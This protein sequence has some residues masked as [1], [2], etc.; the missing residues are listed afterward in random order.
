MTESPSPASVWNNR[1]SYLMTLPTDLKKRPQELTHRLWRQL[2]VSAIA[3]GVR[4]A[5]RK[6]FAQG[7][8]LLRT[9]ERFSQRADL[10]RRTNNELAA[11]VADSYSFYYLRRNKAAAALEYSQRA[12]KAHQRLRNWPHFAKCLLHESMILSH[13]GR[14]DESLASLAG[15][16][17]MVR[18]GSGGSSSN[19][20][21]LCMVAVCYHNIAAEQLMAG[22]F[23]EACASSQNARKLARLCLSYSNRWLH[24]FEG[25]H[26]LALSGL[27]ANMAESDAAAGRFHGEAQ[28]EFLLKLSE[29]LCST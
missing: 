3:F 14:H 7:L 17:A 24:H 23:A 10:D 25:T 20:Q 5:E 22:R 6:K 28:A 26:K 1:H 18:R 21:Q 15:V 13:L 2:A 9:A 12:L 16:L 4:C 19:A 11:Y 29:E 27:A 8:D